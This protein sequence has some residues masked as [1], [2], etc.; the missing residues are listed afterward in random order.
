MYL[1]STLANIHGLG[2]LADCLMQDSR[3]HAACRAF[4]HGLLCHTTSRPINQG[5]YSF[6]PFLT[7]SGN[8]QGQYFSIL[9]KL[10]YNEMTQNLEL[11][12]WIL[13][14]CYQWWPFSKSLKCGVPA[15]FPQQII[16]QGAFHY[17]QSIES[18]DI[19]ST[20]WLYCTSRRVEYP[21]IFHSATS[22]MRMSNQIA[23]WRC[24]PW[25]KVQWS[26]CVERRSV[27]HTILWCNIHTHGT[28]QR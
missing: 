13:A 10:L 21:T 6:R 11:Q 12:D 15:V 16:Y 18:I 9:I 7:F 5:K 4:V 1:S 20:F 8:Y 27:S 14:K 22:T 2:S 28:V 3:C 26:L 23:L 25:K 19:S 24:V 17:I